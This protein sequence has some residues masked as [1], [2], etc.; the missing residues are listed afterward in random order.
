M[1]LLYYNSK[2]FIQGVPCE[3]LILLTFV[4]AVLVVKHCG[5][6]CGQRRD[7]RLFAERELAQFIR[8]IMEFIYPMTRIP[9]DYE[10]A[11]L[12][13]PFECECADIDVNLYR[14]HFGQFFRFDV[15]SQ[16]PFFY[17]SV[18]KL[19]VALCRNTIVDVATCVAELSEFHTVR[20]YFNPQ[21]IRRPSGW[22]T[23]RDVCCLNEQWPIRHGEWR[24]CTA[25][26]SWCD[27]VF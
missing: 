17:K 26:I 19:L 3:Y 20:P 25:A 2:R 14:L 11:I 10:V 24:H 21:W 4:Y 15:S 9:A 23:S 18:Q 5:Q 27:T 8:G 12:L 1:Y 6:L 16:L 13:K 22:R 7:R